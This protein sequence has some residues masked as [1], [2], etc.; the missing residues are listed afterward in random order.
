[1]GDIDLGGAMLFCAIIGAVAG[2]SLLG[3]IW[4]LVSIL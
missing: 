1:M 3:L 2:A 4:L